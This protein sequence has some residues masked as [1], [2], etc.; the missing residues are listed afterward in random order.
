MGEPL[1][2]L[3]AAPD[4]CRTERTDRLQNVYAFYIFYS[5]NKETL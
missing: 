1:G 5:I 4:V 2:M 3:K